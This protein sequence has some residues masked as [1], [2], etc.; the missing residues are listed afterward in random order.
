MKS[1]KLPPDLP[2]R[3]REVSEEELDAAMVH[4]LNNAVVK[5]PDCGRPWE[6]HKYDDS[7]RH[8]PDNCP[9]CGQPWED[10]EFCVPSPCCPIGF[11]K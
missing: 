7:G 6:D 3:G 4:G 5:C 1:P 11:P 10:H 9:D 2:S 8:C